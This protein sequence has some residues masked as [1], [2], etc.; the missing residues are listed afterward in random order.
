M[1]DACGDVKTLRS[2]VSG[3]VLAVCM[4]KQATATV[5]SN[6]EYKNLICPGPEIEYLAGDYKTALQSISTKPIMATPF[7]SLTETWHTAS[8]PAISPSRPELSAANKTVVITG[9]VRTP[10]FFLVMARPLTHQSR[11]ALE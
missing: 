10:C 4:I 9:G 2:S 6:D 1:V 8:Y 5:P 7:P 11:R 3:G